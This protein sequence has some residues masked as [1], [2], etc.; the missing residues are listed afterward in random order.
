MKRL[1]I[2]PF[3]SLLLCFSC[4]KALEIVPQNSITYGNIHNE[5]D[6]ESLMHAVENAVRMN[7]NYISQNWSQDYYRYF[8]EGSRLMHLRSDLKTFS[9]SPTMPWNKYYKIIHQANIPLHYLD[10]TNMTEERKN[11]YR[12]RAYFYKAFAY[13]WLIKTWGD[14]I[15]IKDD[16]ILDPVAKTPWPVVADYAIDLAEKAITFLPQYSEIKDAQGNAPINKFTACKGAAYALLADLAAWKAGARYLAQ[17]KDATYD[18]LSL[19]KKAE[20]SCTNIIESGQYTLAANP[21][22]VCESVLVGD[23]RESLFESDI[24]RYWD[25]ITIQNQGEPP[26]DFVRAPY[27]P[28]YF[29][30]TPFLT[31]VTIEERILLADSVK[32]LFSPIDLRRKS[33]FYKLDSLSNEPTFK[34]HVFS[35]KFRKIKYGTSGPDMGKYVGVFQNLIFWRLAGIYLLRAE[36]RARLGETAGA[37]ADLNVIRGRSQAIPYTSAEGDLRHAIYVERVKK[38][39]LFEPHSFWFDAI[40][41]GYIRTEPTLKTFGYDKLSNQDLIDG[42]LF[43]GINQNDFWNNPLLRQNTYWFKRFGQ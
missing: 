32:K 24:R 29:D 3:F 9:S 36:C 28:Q 41:N 6:I 10:Q 12:G 14:V 35:N 4:K 2:L 1:Y 31:W 17:P 34:G 18:E 11:Y 42:A 20:E 8:N 27:Q 43:E 39:L 19:W 5:K 38:E 25:E 26:V 30:G 22:E 13:L 21:E 33:W 16:V 40:R 37:I 15:L 7:G 23:S